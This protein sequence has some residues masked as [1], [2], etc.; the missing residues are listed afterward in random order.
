M[1][2]S[3]D[4]FDYAAA[5]CTTISQFSNA[6]GS[7]LLD[8][9][10]ALTAN[11]KLHTKLY[12]LASVLK[13]CIIEA[14]QEETLQR[15]HSAC[16]HTDVRMHATRKKRCQMEVTLYSQAI[17]FFEQHWLCGHTFDLIKPPV[18]QTH[19][20]TG[21]V[22]LPCAPL[23]CS[24]ETR[25]RDAQM[26]DDVPLVTTTA[27]SLLSS[28]MPLIHSH[29]ASPEAIPTSND[30]NVMYQLPL[31]LRSNALLRNLGLELL[32]LNAKR[33]RAYAETAL[34]TV[35][36]GNCCGFDIGPSMSLD[37]Q[38]F[39]KDADVYCESE[40]YDVKN[41]SAEGSCGDYEEYDI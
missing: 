3:P 11:Q 25:E 37:W 27:P 40:G 8:V 17:E 16:T 14:K 20:P 12:V 22:P 34:Y 13:K 30:L 10:I 33:C 15:N 9:Y 38:R 5:R 4:S 24:I 19:A 23:A 28:P 18:R 7:E 1:S 41:G 35:A 32:I 2:L 39:G 31:R 26:S 6:L 29:S 21:C 36:I